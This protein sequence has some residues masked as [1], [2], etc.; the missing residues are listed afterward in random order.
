MDVPGGTAGLLVGEAQVAAEND[1]WPCWS[2]Q[3]L[4]QKGAN[5]HPTDPD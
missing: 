3:F 1:D 4:L 5:V 2:I